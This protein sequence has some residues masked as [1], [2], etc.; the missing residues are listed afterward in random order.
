VANLLPALV[1]GEAPHWLPRRASECRRHVVLVIDGIGWHQL[2]ER[3]ASAPTLA[4]MSG[5][6]ITTVAPSTTATGL[7]S[8]ATGTPP[9]EHG[10]VGYRM[11]ERGD[12]V[13]C[14]R[15]TV[16]GKDVRQRLDPTRVQPVTPFVGTKP[17]VVTK[18]EF[19]KTGFTAAHLRGGVHRG[20]RTT[21]GIAVEVGAAIAAGEPLVYA[22]YDGLDKIAHEYGLGAHYEAELAF[23]DRLVADVRAVLP[24][25]VALVVTAD[26]GQVHVGDNVRKLD[27][28]LVAM[29]HGQSGEGR[30]RWLHT[31]R[32]SDVHAQAAEQF[33]DVAWVV[34]AEQVCDEGWFG[35]VVT[36]AARARLG[37]VAL[38]AS[39][40]V[41]FDDPADTGELKL[42]GRHGS[43]TAAE[44]HV[45]LLVS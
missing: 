31:R 39:A 27:P 2:D 12:V 4:A 14:L 33:G 45:P 18:G 19:A 37:D 7:T 8:I 41:S 20:W 32:V 25:D 24:D 36:T 40:P 26:H 34:T 11:W 15:W 6:P 42:V 10:V 35:P 43:L 13:N 9:G 38:V 22:Y 28:S 23:V 3:R 1:G 17:V 5:G 16:A 29:C 44:M 21:S 30:F